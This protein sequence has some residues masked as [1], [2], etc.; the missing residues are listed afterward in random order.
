MDEKRDEREKISPGAP[1][2]QELLA[3]FN[4]ETML[5]KGRF[6]KFNV[7]ENADELS[8]YNPS[9][10]D[11]DGVTYLLARVEKKNTESGSTVML[12][13][14]NENGEWDIVED[15]PVLNNVQDPFYCGMI[16]GLHVIGWVQT[17][18]ETGSP[19]LGYRT[20]FYRFENSIL[21]LEDEDSNSIPPF[22]VGPEKMKDIRL[23]QRKNGRIGVFTR[24]QGKFGGR[25]EVGYFEIENLDQL[26]NSLADHVQKEEPDSLIFNVFLKRPKGENEWGGV[27][28]LYNLADGK[29]GVL[30][31]I[32]DIEPQGVKK[33][34]Y[35]ITFIFDPETRLISDLKIIAT[36]KQFPPVK[37]KKFDLGEVLY[38]GGLV[39]LGNDKV[40]LYVGIGDTEAGYID[41]KDPFFK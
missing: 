2:I 3:V 37:A 36:T 33:S 6:L 24:P 34:Y 10:I 14:E 11:V 39:S 5:P 27:N 22:A 15:V 4:K 26:E 19:Q 25:G 30:G 41:I 18:E 31:H 29:I 38:S 16:D 8:V 40:R 21:E 9:P 23:I 35:P 17:Y 7:D 20:V 32:A 28:E 12:F 1:G 13:C